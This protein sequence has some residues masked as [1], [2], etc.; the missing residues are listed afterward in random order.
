MTGCCFGSHAYLPIFSG[1]Q[2]KRSAVPNPRTLQITKGNKIEPAD[3][4]QAQ[5]PQPADCWFRRS[6]KTRENRARRDRSF[7]IRCNVH[8]GCGLS[9][10]RTYDSYGHN[11]ASNSDMVS[12]KL[13]YGRKNTGPSTDLGRPWG[14]PCIRLRRVRWGVCLEIC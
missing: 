5:S 4:N 13:N 8:L 3:E 11:L 2:A 14:L 12:P 6:S 9:L 10:W 1:E 7:E